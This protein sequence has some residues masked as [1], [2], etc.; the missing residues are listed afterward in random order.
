MADHFSSQPLNYL[1]LDKHGQ[2]L[3]LFFLILGLKRVRV[4]TVPAICGLLNNTLFEIEVLSAVV[5]E[6]EGARCPYKLISQQDGN[7]HAQKT[8]QAKRIVN[9]AHFFATD[10]VLQESR[11]SGLAVNS[12]T[13]KL[14][15]LV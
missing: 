4:T 5:V 12:E 14:T 2:S 8:H 1:L 11:L 10:F 7:H 3:F 13:K 6:R 9:P 15:G